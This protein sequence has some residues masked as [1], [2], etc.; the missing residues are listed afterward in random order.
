MFNIDSFLNKFKNLTPPDGEI[1]EKVSE[2]I[3]NEINIEIDKKYISIKNGS[4]YIKTKP[5]IKNE[6]FIKKKKL[7]EELR[8]SFGDKTPKDIK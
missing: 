8:K 3:K 6:I 5:I 4:I 7:L 1:R 2:I